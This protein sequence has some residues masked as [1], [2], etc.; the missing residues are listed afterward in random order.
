MQRLLGRHAPVRAVFTYNLAEAMP[1][2]LTPFMGFIGFPLR[3]RKQPAS[4]PG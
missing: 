2:V 3:R 1:W 4:T